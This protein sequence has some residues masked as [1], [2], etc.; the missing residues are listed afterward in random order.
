M[1]IEKVALHAEAEI[2]GYIDNAE[3]ILREAGYDDAER[4]A[5]LPTVIGLFATHT[6]VTHQEPPLPLDLGIF[7]GK[8]GRA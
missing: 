6:I 1:R 8:V 7:G 2:K 3:R 5:L 4:V